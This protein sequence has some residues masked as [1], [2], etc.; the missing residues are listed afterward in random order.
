[1]NAWQYYLRLSDDIC[2][3]QTEYRD[4]MLAE[5]PEGAERL[6]ALKV[7]CNNRLGTRTAADRERFLLRIGA[8]QTK[9]EPNEFG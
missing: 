2:E 3:G 5:Y 4:R 6:R 8:I 9:G 7:Y 1:M